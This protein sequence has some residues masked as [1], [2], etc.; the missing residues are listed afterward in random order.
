MIQAA[1]TSRFPT[2]NAEGSYHI[3]TSA[4]WRRVERV[5]ITDNKPNA[6]LDAI[7]DCGMT[8]LFTVPPVRTYSPAH[9]NALT[10]GLTRVDRGYCRQAPGAVAGQNQGNAGTRAELGVQAEPA[11]VRVPHREPADTAF[12]ATILALASVPA[13]PPG[14]PGIA[15]DVP[16]NLRLARRPTR[17]RMRLAPTELSYTRLSR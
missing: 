15:H 12:H 2:A 9:G 6:H 5:P 1:I 13:R 17:H 10:S 7:L 3:V 11:R 16:A 4:G 14:R 8:A